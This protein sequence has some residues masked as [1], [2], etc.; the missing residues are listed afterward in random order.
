MPP[1]V[2]SKRMVLLAGLGG[3]VRNVLRN[4]HRSRLGMLKINAPSTVH[5]DRCTRDCKLQLCS[6]AA[7]ISSASTGSSSSLSGYKFDAR[8]P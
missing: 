5:T 7:V 1:V 8:E 6:T 2:E 3:V 4:L